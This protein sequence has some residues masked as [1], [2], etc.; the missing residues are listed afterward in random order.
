MGGRAPSLLQSS[1]YVLSQSMDEG[2]Y[3]PHCATGMCMFAPSK[4]LEHFGWTPSYDL[5]TDSENLSL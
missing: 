5:S 4:N 3:R 2:V 1:G